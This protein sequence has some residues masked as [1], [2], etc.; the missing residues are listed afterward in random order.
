MKV[1]P[2]VTP[3]GSQ[4]VTHAEGAHRIIKHAEAQVRH[5]VNEDGVIAHEAEAAPLATV[6]ETMTGRKR[7]LLR[8]HLQLGRTET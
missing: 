3:E 1:H 2:D 7:N 8:H 5:V 6:D 4:E